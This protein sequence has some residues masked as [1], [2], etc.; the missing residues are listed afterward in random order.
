MT[1]SRSFSAPE[2]VTEKTLKRVQAAVEATGYIPNRIAGSLA[3]SRSRTVGVIIPNLTN[4]IFADKVHDPYYGRAAKQDHLVYLEHGKPLRYGKELEK[5]LVLNG[6]NIAA[7]ENPADS[8]VI[9]HDSRD[10]GG[11]L[12]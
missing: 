4:S 2:M 12:A 10:A 8:E 11:A 1:V 7:K 6:F 3:S 5:G 9:V